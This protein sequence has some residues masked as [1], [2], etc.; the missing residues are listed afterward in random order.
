RDVGYRLGE[1]HTRLLL[2]DGRFAEAAS[3]PEGWMRGLKNRG[4]VSNTAVATTWL[5]RA[6]LMA[7]DAGT[8][9]RLAQGVA[10]QALTWNRFEA[11]T[12]AWILLSA[13]ELAEGDP[14]AAL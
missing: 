4:A 10:G 7:G 5:G 8:A 3:A 12:R 14:R 13:V 6:H 9:R 1:L 2:A 11:H